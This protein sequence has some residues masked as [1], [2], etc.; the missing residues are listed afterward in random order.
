MRR[1]IAIAMTTWGLACAPEIGTE[2]GR[3][4]SAP[5]EE[6]L[7]LRLEPPAPLEA[8]APISRFVVEGVEGAADAFHL[9]SGEIR[10]AHLGQLT[11]GAISK[12]LA[13]RAV[14]ALRWREGDRVILAPL[15][16]L[17]PGAVYAVAT[18]VPAWAEHI[19]IAA[20]D[21]V[22]VLEPVF[23]PEGVSTGAAPFGIWCGDVALPPFER[24]IA[25]AP[26]GRAAT[27]SGGAVPG[28][29]LRCLA[30]AAA[31]GLGPVLPPLEVT[32]EATLARLAPVA[33]DAIPEAPLPPAQSACAP[34]AK[35]VAGAC[36]TVFDDRARLAP[37]DATPLLWVATAPGL[38]QVIVTEG[39]ARVIRP[40][41]PGSTVSLRIARVDVAG[42]LHDEEIVVT[43]APP[44]AHL[45]VSEV[46]ADALGPEP[47]Q[48]WVEICNDGLAASPLE[49]WILADNG[50]ET[51]L[52]AATL[53]P[54]ACALVVHEDF[55]ARY[56]WDAI[57]PEGTLLLRVP[58]IGKNGLAN[59]GEPL[60]LRDPEGAVRSRFPPV[61]KP[62]AGHSVVRVALD[63]V[64]DD[65]A[66]FVRT[67]APTPGTPP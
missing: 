38:D 56:P 20:D 32:A 49:G 1:G 16:V 40:L 35:S 8:G 60:E 50:G 29:G 34:P 27:L 6:A 45:V 14:P 5:D 31:P 22:P 57:P 63:A 30:I 2:G 61:P 23:P 42:G 37:P 52:P 10:S 39:Y 44:S 55:D 43:T 51:V 28:R 47:E 59:G 21:A 24:A 3:V 13:D 36:L 58:E 66:S 48:E 7:A 12:A 62:K 67:D 17:A 11:K 18:G 64:D 33:L 53:A 65:P 4:A 25:L 41:P 46:Y 54:G 26:D 9:F 19:T 15:A